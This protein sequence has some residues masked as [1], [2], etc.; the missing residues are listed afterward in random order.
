[1]NHKGEPSMTIEHSKA[2]GLALG[3][4]LEQARL[5]Q[6]LTQE[7]MADI[8]KLSLDKIIEMESYVDLSSLSP[9]DRG[10]VRNYA[11]KVELD[12]ESF[13]LNAQE[14]KK[15]AAELQPIS[16]EDWSKPFFPW[17]KVLVGLAVIGLISAA[18]AIYFI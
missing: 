18:L 2:P 10:Y 17:L 11:G 13:E 4:A 9:F 6:D 8:M 15:I 16:K 14:L 1:V 12:L 3:E 5:K 7:A